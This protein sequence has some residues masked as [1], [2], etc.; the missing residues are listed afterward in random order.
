MHQKRAETILGE[1]EKSQLSWVLPRRKKVDFRSLSQ[2]LWQVLHVVWDGKVSIERWYLSPFVEKP[3]NSKVIKK[4]RTWTKKS[5]VFFVF[6]YTYVL[7]IY[8]M[9]ILCTFHIF[10]SG[11]DTPLN[12]F[13]FSDMVKLIVSLFAFFDFTLWSA[14]TAKFNIQ[15]ILFF[16][17]FFFFLADDYLVC[18]L[19]K[20]FVS[21]N[22]REFSVPDFPVRIQ[23]CA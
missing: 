13:L 20:R 16:F 9:N 3:F 11:K 1:F 23:S 14:E 15:L 19:V 12:L 18:S 8:V 4:F 22:P 10:I 17:S 6:R 2:V 7:C 5:H 21:Q